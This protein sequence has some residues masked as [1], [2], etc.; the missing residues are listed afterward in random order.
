MAYQ[1]HFGESNAYV[2]AG[3]MLSMSMRAPIWAA[4]FREC[5]R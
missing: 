5:V 4:S 2:E 3:M 1:V